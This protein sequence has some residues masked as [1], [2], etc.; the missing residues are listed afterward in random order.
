LIDNLIEAV[1]ILGSIFYG[2]VL[3]IFLVA[4]FFKR[5]TGTPVLFGAACAQVAVVALFVA[6]DLGYLWFNL[7][8]SAIVVLVAC[9]LEEVRRARLPA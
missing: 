2:T 4:F 9:A 3:G 6:S 5:V 1:N 7:V 8:G